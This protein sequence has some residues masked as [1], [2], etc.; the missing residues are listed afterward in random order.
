MKFSAAD[1]RGCTQMKSK[2]AS[3]VVI[4]SEAKNPYC[5]GIASREQQARPKSIPS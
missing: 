2:C 3:Y 4:L 5:A 1:Q